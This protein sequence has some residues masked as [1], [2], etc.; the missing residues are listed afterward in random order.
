MEKDNY[1]MLFVAIYGFQQL[2]MRAVDLVDDKGVPTK[3]QKR[4]LEELETIDLYNEVSKRLKHLNQPQVQATAKKVNDIVMNQLV[5]NQS[6]INNYLLALMLFRE[7]LDLEGTTFERNRFAGKV[8]RQIAIYEALEGEKYKDIRK[9]TYRVAN[10]LF[11]VFIG[12]PQLDD[13][14]RDLMAKR[15]MK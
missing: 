4:P 13:D 9:E 3:D 15:W 5:N 14:L 12:K 7:W 8:G 6:K 2:E 10:N 1:E 11:R